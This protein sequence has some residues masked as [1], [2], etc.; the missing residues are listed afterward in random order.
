[1]YLAHCMLY[2]QRFFF[3]CNHGKKYFCYLVGRIFMK[4]LS[5]DFHL[6]GSQNKHRLSLHSL[7]YQLLINHECVCLPKYVLVFEDQ[8][9]F[10]ANTTSHTCNKKVIFKFRNIQSKW[11]LFC[12]YK[13]NIRSSLELAAV[14]MLVSIFCKRFKLTL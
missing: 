8:S 9:H 14:H 10:C 6:V 2:R 12:Q 5:F 3:Y 13:I 11:K 1:M 4:N 7:F